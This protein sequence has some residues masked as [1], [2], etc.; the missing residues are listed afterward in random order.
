MHFEMHLISAQEGPKYGRVQKQSVWGA[1]AK[2]TGF[3]LP[4][5]LSLF[6]QNDRL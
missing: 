1:R 4:E 5:L 6:Q 2:A 3:W